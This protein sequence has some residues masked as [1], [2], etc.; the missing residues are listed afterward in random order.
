M[1]HRY[2]IGSERTRLLHV[3]HAQRPLQTITSV[4]LL[5]HSDAQSLG[6]GTYIL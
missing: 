6:L 1:P 5:I 3:L 4:G 2:P